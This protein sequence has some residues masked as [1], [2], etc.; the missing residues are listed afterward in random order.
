MGLEAVEFLLDLEKALG[1]SI[2]DTRW[3]SVSWLPDDTG[4]YYTRYPA[5]L[6]Y[7]QRVWFHRV[8]DDPAKDA[9]VFGDGRSCAPERFGGHP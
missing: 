1:L 3:T 6:R 8:G 5:G 2:P 4:F 9:K 7:D